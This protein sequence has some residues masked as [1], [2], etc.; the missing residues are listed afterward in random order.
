VIVS[1]HRV[2]RHHLQTNST[3]VDAGSR[4]R[5]AATVGV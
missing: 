5:S 4:P 3:R 1:G 2:H